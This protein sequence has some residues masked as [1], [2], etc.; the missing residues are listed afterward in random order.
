MIE[1]KTFGIFEEKNIYQASLVSSSGVVLNILNYGALI[2]DWKVPVNG[3]SR[4]MVLGFD[5]FDPYPMLSPY[6]GAI[7]GRVANRIGG[8]SFELEGHTYDLELNERS[9][10]LHGGIQGLSTQ[11]WDME[12]DTWNNKIRLSHVSENGAM[13]Y[14]GQ[15]LFEV[16][17]NLLGNR[18]RV[19]FS[20][21]PDHK[22]PISL[23]QHNYFN[24]GETN[25]VL[26]HSLLIA[27]E[28]FTPCDEHLIPTGEILSVKDRTF[29]FRQVKTMRGP[30]G[31]GLNLDMN[32][33]L[34]KER[35]MQQPVAQAFSPNGDISL[36]LF[37]DRPGLQLFNSA[38]MDIK[39]VG[40]SGVKYGAFAGFCLE[41]QM[42]PDA[43]H[44]SNFPSIICDPDHPY[45]HWCEIEIS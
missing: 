17:Y 37:T 44:H 45:S 31:H 32:F 43:L 4:S 6:F 22:T 23:A 41:D 30:E 5:S 14:P 16:A 33:V 39:S 19:E 13:G 29:D 38:K 9:H 11:I 36:K 15:V 3:V 18:L 20:A 1:I 24:L 26:D 25:H 2:Q 12:T 34:C 27:A 40:H 42:L 7:V 10:H 28:R 21:K 8:G 35:D